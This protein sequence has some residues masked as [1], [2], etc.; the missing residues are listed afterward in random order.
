MSNSKTA[1][2]N[3]TTAVA[4][5]TPMA[6][7]KPSRKLNSAPAWQPKSRQNRRNPNKSSASQQHRDQQI[8]LLHQA[9]VEKMLAEPS[10]AN[11]ILAQLDQRYQQG[12]L[13]HN[14]YLF[15]S[16]ALLQLEQ[17]V[18]FRQALLGDDAQSRKYRRRTAL[19]AILTEAERQAIL[20]GQH[21]AA[22]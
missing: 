8:W 20:S 6:A 14:E 11:R 21:A 2:I 16:S 22:T 12:L 13:R 10:H 7:L 9:M 1:N 3:N 4:A 15:W 5:Q 17:P 19:T 18:L